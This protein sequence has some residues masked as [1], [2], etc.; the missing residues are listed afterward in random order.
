MKLLSL[1]HNYSSLNRNFVIARSL[2]QRQSSAEKSFGILLVTVW[3]IMSSFY[4]FH[5]PMYKF[6]IP[7]HTTY[8]TLLLCHII[9]S[10]LTLNKSYEIWNFYKKG[11]IK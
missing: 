7:L 2:F 9:K 11:L 10:F 6:L 8:I 5:S 4:Y 3:Y 1:Y